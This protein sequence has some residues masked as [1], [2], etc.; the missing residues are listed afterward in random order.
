MTDESIKQLIQA[1]YNNREIEHR[2]GRARSSMHSQIRRL[3]NELGI[4]SPGRRSTPWAPIQQNEIEANLPE[5][6]REYGLKGLHTY[7]LSQAELQEIWRKY[8]RPGEH[9]EEYDDTSI[10]ADQ[11]LIETAVAIRDN[12]QRRS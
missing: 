7:P 4:P 3:R 8:G 2:F 9:A 12:M 1:G 6:K 5:P 11:Y 10:E